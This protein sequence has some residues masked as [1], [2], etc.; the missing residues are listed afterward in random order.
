MRE[1]EVNKGGLKEENIKEENGGGD[2]VGSG[3]EGDMAECR[4]EGEDRGEQGRWMG[5][6]LAI[7]SWG[8]GRK[9]AGYGTPELIMLELEI[10][11]GAQHWKGCL[12]IAS[13]N[14]KDRGGGK[15]KMG[16]RKEYDGREIGN[17]RIYLREVG[18]D[19]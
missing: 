13:K 5:Q 16:E 6:K 15:V 9:A 4:G 11:D 17:E 8:V 18:D 7:V 14:G 19:G 10:D 3:I 2:Y 12:E 1:E